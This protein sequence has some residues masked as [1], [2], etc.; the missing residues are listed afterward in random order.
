MKNNILLYFPWYEDVHFHKD[1]GQIPCLL[2]KKLNYNFYI[3]TKKKSS[4]S[5]NKNISFIFYKNSF[6]RLFT[7]MKQ[8]ILLQP[9]ISI[10]FF[11]NIS[12]LFLVLL[13][14]IFSS[15]KIYVKW[16][17]DFYHFSSKT[18]K[19]KFFY[20]K[21]KII[22]LLF[23]VFNIV[24]S[25][26]TKKTFEFIK[27]NYNVKNL[28]YIPNG[29]SFENKWDN[30][31][32]KENIIITVGRLWTIQKNTQLF[33][34]IAW[35]FL[36]LDIE[37]KWKF[38]AIW[39]IDD[40][41]NFLDYKK[42]FFEKYPIYQDKIIFTWAINDRREITNYYEKAKIFLM[43]S[44]FEWSPLVLPEATINWCLLVTSDKIVSFYDI[45]NNWKYWF[46]FWIDDKNIGEKLYE[47]V[48]KSS[49]ETFCE[50]QRNYTIANFTW[51]VIIEKLLFKLH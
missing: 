15:S 47:Y 5:E 43:P 40:E 8:I 3:F 19:S 38:Y 18:E 9:K 16:D 6:L 13:T 12:T 31:P 24:Y 29:T 49:L 36:D 10:Y 41:T 32:E 30:L 33:L 27:W 48:N 20:L 22:F 21:K 35:N 14:R 28:L 11:F 37:K 51:E 42:D 4:I 44:R 46:S 25:V 34:D 23:D 26:E 45:T 39:P 50:Q 2:S 17:I 7:F 1:V